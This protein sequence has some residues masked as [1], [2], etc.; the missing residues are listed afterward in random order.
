[1]CHI[2]LEDPLVSRHHAR[3]RIVGTEARIQDL[4]SRNGVRVNGRLIDGE[5]TLADGDR[6]RLGSQEL[7]FSVVRGRTRDVRPTG[8]MQLCG[9]CGRARAQTASRCPHCGATEVVDEDTVSGV[10]AE[11]RRGWQF[12]LLADVIDRALAMGRYAEVERMLRRATREVDERLAA[13]ERLEPADLTR[14]SVQVLRFA[15]A[16]GGAEWVAWV[17]GLHGRERLAPAPEVLERLES[18]DAD[19]LGLSRPALLSYLDVLRRAGER[20]RPEADAAVARL[21]RLTRT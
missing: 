15:A 5:R 14:L 11:P 6:I 19:V 2:T 18:L 12:A 13:G 9:Q 4:G 21:E 16:Q 10:V 17:V 7:V 8:A 1:D 20:A 3:I